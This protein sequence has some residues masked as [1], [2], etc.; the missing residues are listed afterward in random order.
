M[1]RWTQRSRDGERW[2]GRQGS[3]F[4][5]I[6]YWGLC[7]GDTYLPIEDQSKLKC[8]LDSK[9]N[10][11]FFLKPLQVEELARE[12]EI[13]Q[14]YNVLSSSSID[15][16]IK[17]AEP[18][19]NP[20]FVFKFQENS[21]SEEDVHRSYHRTSYSTR[22]SELE[23][24]ESK[25]VG[26]LV[27]LITGMEILSPGSSELLQMI[28]YTLGGHYYLHLDAVNSRFIMFFSSMQ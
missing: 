23:F 27:E 4:M 6:N 18:K 7:S 17:L 24:V 21:S 28:S 2:G 10:P 13:V 19:L 22:L 20:S 3:N 1:S 15:K 9:R 25:K 8:W 14:I 12:P 5:E 16:L 11:Y 26:R